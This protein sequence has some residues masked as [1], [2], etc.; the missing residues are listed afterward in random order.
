MFSLRH[1]WYAP[2]TGTFF[3]KHYR[4]V[5][6]SGKCRTTWRALLELC[7]LKKH[8]FNGHNWSVIWIIQ[9]LLAGSWTIKSTSSLR[10]L[11]ASAVNSSASLL[12]VD[13]NFTE[14]KIQNRKY[15]SF[16]VSFIQILDQFITLAFGIVIHRNYKR[17]YE[18]TPNISFFFFALPC[19][20]CVSTIQ[21]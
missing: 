17:S 10:E 21:Q 2:D 12:S 15:N 18:W 5:M 14:K 11:T 20:N 7:Y 16:C 8:R 13:V 1:S 6:S 4:S 9:L 3:F 19:F